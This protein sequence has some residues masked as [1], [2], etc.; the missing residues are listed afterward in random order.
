MFHVAVYNKFPFVLARKD[1]KVCNSPNVLK[2]DS[3]SWDFYVP[4]RPGRHAVNADRR[5]EDCV[6]RKNL[7]EWV[8]KTPPR[9][10]WLEQTISPSTSCW[11][12]ESPFAFRGGIPSLWHVFSHLLLV[13][14]GTSEGGISSPYVQILRRIT[15]IFSTSWRRWEV[16]D[17]HPLGISAARGSLISRF[18][19]IF[20]FQDNIRLPI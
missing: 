18:L 1:P 4:T 11:D 7:D 12:G 19:E 3:V 15:S 5:T 14:W 9:P 16:A 20:V 13:V 6:E 2:V 10:C 8:G 17:R